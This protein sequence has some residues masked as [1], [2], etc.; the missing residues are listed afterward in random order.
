MTQNFLLYH[1]LILIV[2]LLL[3]LSSC[4]TY[5]LAR[6]I[7]KIRFQPNLNQ[8]QNYFQLSARRND[9]KTLTGSQESG[10]NDIV[11]SQLDGNLNA[12]RIE[13][14]KCAIASAIGGSLIALPVNLAIG[15]YINHFNAS[16]EFHNDTMAIILLLFGLVYRY[17]TR[18]DPNIQI[19][20][21]VVTAFTLTR[22]ISSIDVPSFC[23]SL[24]LD[25]G[26]P[27]HY[28][29]LSM[30]FQGVQ[31]G[32]ESLAGFASAAYVIEFLAA[33]KFISM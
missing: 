11:E 10:R 19:K 8:L 32:V 4:H 27:F 23:S 31:S 24:P 20:F 28:F 14:G 7:R 1:R 5:N 22:A 3:H 6:T 12:D 21:G 9:D 26:D 13:S 17:S 29:T 16:W 33:R 2:V 15:S 25:C 18:K 30:V